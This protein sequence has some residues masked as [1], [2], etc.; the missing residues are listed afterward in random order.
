[1]DSRRFAKTVLAGTLI[2]LVTAG[3]LTAVIDPFFHFHK[4]LK[5]YL[6]QNQSR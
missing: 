4:P 6:E 2:L 3:G 5:S 1:M